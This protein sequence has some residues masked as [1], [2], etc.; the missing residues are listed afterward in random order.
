MSQHLLGLNIQYLAESIS[1]LCLSLHVI[2]AH[3]IA[4]VLTYIFIRNFKKNGNLQ[5]ETLHIVIYHKVDFDL[6]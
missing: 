4:E 5:I 1:R 3:H 6:K 2:L